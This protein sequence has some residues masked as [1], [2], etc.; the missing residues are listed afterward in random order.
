M[1][2]LAQLEN[3]ILLIKQR[4]R[5]VEADKAW[6]TSL[7]RR[8]AIVALTYAVAV[9]A[10]F[11]MGFAKPFESAIIP[12]LAFLLSTLTLE[13]FKRMWLANRD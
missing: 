5:K 11:S 4:N 7:Q 2:S 9:A 1:A 6:E 12:A 8:V 3:E 10:F 13:T